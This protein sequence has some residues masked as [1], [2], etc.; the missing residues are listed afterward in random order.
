MVSYDFK[1]NLTTIIS[2]Y[3]IPIL[4]GYGVSSETANAITGIIVALVIIG[5]GMLNE[6][7]ISKHLTKDNPECSCEYEEV[8]EIGQDSETA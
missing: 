8:E 2:T 4:V 1:A 5:F 7:Y 6:R 3:L